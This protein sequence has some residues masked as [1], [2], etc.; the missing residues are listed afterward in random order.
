MK[1]FS[2]IIESALQALHKAEATQQQTGDRKPRLSKWEPIPRSR[3][4][5]FR[6]RGPKGDW[7]Y[8]YPKPGLAPP[9]DFNLR[10]A[11][12]LGG[13]KRRLQ[14]DGK[15]GSGS[16]DGSG[17]KDQGIEDSKK[18]KKAKIRIPITPKDKIKDASFPHEKVSNA[19]VLS[20]TSDEVVVKIGRREFT[21]GS[22][23]GAARSLNG[24]GFYAR[25]V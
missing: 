2:D 6:K 22:K 21:F 14:D 20:A 9:P 15:S 24:V 25:E 19:K 23:K 4:G 10:A 16:D 1:S 7:R 12:G 13:K 18:K 8:Y 3:R 17:K 5:G 11:T